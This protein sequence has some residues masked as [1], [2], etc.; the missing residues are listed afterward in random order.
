MVRDVFTYLPVIAKRI[1]CLKVLTGFNV[2]HCILY[3]GNGGFMA[4]VCLGYDACK[5][6]N[7]IFYKKLLRK[8]YIC[9]KLLL[10]AE[11]T[12]TFYHQL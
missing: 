8:S 2:I 10:V 12:R 9:D 3:L 7:E 1:T 4:Y 11:M 5:N 6:D